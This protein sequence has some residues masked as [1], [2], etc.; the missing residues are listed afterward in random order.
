VFIWN[1]PSPPDRNNIHLILRYTSRA[2]QK[3]QIFYSPAQL[4]V[5]NPKLL[6]GR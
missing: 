5:C 2:T 4:S 3:K 6:A 1:L